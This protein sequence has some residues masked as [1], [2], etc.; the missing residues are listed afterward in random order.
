MSGEVG[1]GLWLRKRRLERRLTQGELADLAGLSRRWL[2]EIEAGRSEAKFSDVLRLV[3]ALDAD[4]GEV[5]G[6]SQAR[7]TAAAASKLS[8]Q[9]AEE[10]K[11][12][13][14]LAGAVGLAG[15]VMVDWERIVAATVA[16]L[17]EDSALDSLETITD[18]YARLWKTAPP[19]ALLR[20]L[21]AH[22]GT[23][24]TL[25]PAAQ[26]HRLQA[27]TA[28]TAVLAGYLAF[29]AEDRGQATGYWDMAQ[30]LSA[31]IGGETQARALIA[32]SAVHSTVAY[33]GVLTPSRTPLDLL[34]A[35]EARAGAGTS[36]LVRA[37][38]L[39]RRAEERAALGDAGG[40]DRDLE[41][42]DGCLQEQTTCAETIVGP[43]NSGQLD[44]FRGSCDVLLGRYGEAIASLRR[45]LDG[46]PA[47]MVAW[48]SVVH[49]DLGAA[50]AGLG[51]VEEACTV[52]SAALRL[53][54][55]A[56]APEHVHRVHGVRH[57]L[58]V[59][60]AEP[61]VRRLDEELLAV[62]C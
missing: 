25:L 36:R 29:Q 53:A 33:G 21:H 3:G 19:R 45:S 57:R 34:E 12:R 52:L 17:V 31:E 35:A 46:M 61:S 6:V 13:D 18:S 40:A 14:L 38:A 28:D 11:R 15:M 4:L 32:A 41:A 55:V 37:W 5:P 10:A 56:G 23:L 26:G 42:A 39:A 16:P 1:F 54:T 22:L 50:L 27:L 51:E 60:A 2:V 47:S 30:Q 44:G 49:A 48:R 9:E 62:S 20:G 59:H 43:R 7:T 58:H 24:T 8:H